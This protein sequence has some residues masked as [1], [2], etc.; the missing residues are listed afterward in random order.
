MQLVYEA[1]TRQS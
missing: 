1:Q